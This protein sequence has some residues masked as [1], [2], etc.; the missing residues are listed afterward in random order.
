[1]TGN[2]SRICSHMLN[3]GKKLVG[4]RRWEEGLLHCLQTVLLRLS[5]SYYLTYLFYVTIARPTGTGTTAEREQ[6]NEEYEGRDRAAEM[7]SLQRRRWGL[8]C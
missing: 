1:M 7:V 5:T 8:A 6:T 3:G 2:F 4:S